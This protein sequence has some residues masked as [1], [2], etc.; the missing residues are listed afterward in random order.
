MLLVAG[1]MSQAAAYLSAAGYFANMSDIVW[2]SSWL[3][4]DGSVAGQ[5]L[6]VLVGYTAQPSLIQLVFYASTLAVLTLCSMHI[7][8]KVTPPA[9]VS[10]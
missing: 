4:A 9:A 2:D 6:Q 10:A 3:L 5:I 8:R 7:S 1:L